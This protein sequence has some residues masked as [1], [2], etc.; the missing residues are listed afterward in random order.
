MKDMM[1]KDCFC[2]MS[3]S[4]WCHDHVFPQDYVHALNRGSKISGTSAVSMNPA[5]PNTIRTTRAKTGSVWDCVNSPLQSPLLRNYSY[6]CCPKPPSWDDALESQ[7]LNVRSICMPYISHI[8]C[9]IQC[10][11]RV[12]LMSYVLYLVCMYVFPCTYRKVLSVNST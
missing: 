4:S 1:R 9:L 11:C 5:T 8:S 3:T 12:Y 7:K 2:A 10:I 6:M